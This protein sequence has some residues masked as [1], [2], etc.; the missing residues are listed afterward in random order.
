MKFI[1]KNI[2]FIKI[3]NNFE[4]WC[5]YDSEMEFKELQERFALQKQEPSMFKTLY[6]E[7]K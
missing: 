4:R 7:S 3:F 1:G 5:I 6:G 2:H